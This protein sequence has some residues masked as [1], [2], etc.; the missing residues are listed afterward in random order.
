MGI[1]IKIWLAGLGPV[2]QMAGPSPTSR[3]FLKVDLKAC[4]GELKQEHFIF[5][6]K[7]RNSA[8]INYLELGK[9]WKI[10]KGIF[11]KSANI[12]LKS[13]GLKARIVFKWPCTSTS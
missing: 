6:G 8:L 2:S 13:S 12:R 5:V 9:I 1:Q 3:G 4:Q 7:A 10:R 11:L